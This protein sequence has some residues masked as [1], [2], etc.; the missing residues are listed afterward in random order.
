MISI[1][2]AVYNGSEFVEKTIHSAIEQ[3][4]DKEIIIVDDCSTDDSYEIIDSISKKNDF[5]HVFRNDTNLGFC[6]SVNKAAKNASGEYI[7]IL[8]QDDLLEPDHCRKMIEKFDDNVSIVFCDYDLIDE[9]DQVFDSKPHCLNRDVS[10]KDF[11]KDNAIP[12]VGLVLR[13]DEFVSAGGYPEN[14]LYSQYGEYHTWIR[15]ALNGKILFCDSTKAKYRRHKNNMTNSF[16]SKDVLKKVNRYYNTCKMQI[17]KSP[18][19]NLK[20]KVYVLAHMIYRA[21]RVCCLGRF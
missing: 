10:I 15:L 18:Q 5:I 7:L 2:I 11:Y 20:E 6:K 13:R 19:I 16:S 17:I 1:I 14:D 9:D 12:S 8:G 4:I 21:L 3:N